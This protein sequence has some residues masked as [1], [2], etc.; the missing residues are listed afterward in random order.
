MQVETS[1][2]G[3]ID[4]TLWLALHYALID[5][6]VLS[7]NTSFKFL[8]ANNT[9]KWSIRALPHTPPTFNANYLG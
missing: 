9:T 2:Y 8:H 4:S 1:A 6:Y 3:L 5:Q 7:F